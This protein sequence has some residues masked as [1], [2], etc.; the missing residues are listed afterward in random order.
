[1]P[2]YQMVKRACGV[3]L[4]SMQGRDLNSACIT[5]FDS[6]FEPLLNRIKKAIAKLSIPCLF[7]S[8]F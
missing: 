5:H 8:T 6:L 7:R 2:S 3:E 1:M 4:M